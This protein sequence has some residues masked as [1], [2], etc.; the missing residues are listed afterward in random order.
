M[1][2]RKGLF[3]TIDGPNAAGK[4]TA[5]SGVA[6]QLCLL[7]YEVVTTGEPS[8]SEVGQLAR[9]LESECR[10]LAFACLI[11]SDRYFHLGYEV[12]PALADGKIVLS[13][14]YVESSLVLQRLDGVEF[15]LIWTINSKVPVPD[16]SVMLDVPVSILEQRLAERSQLDYYERNASR[17][18]EL[19]YYEDA[20]TFL[21]QHGYTFL[22]LSNGHVA[23]ADT[24]GRITR[25]ILRILECRKQTGR[26]SF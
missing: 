23:I 12:L 20:I 10:G 26:G 14:R 24:V 6:E 9:R 13:A 22:R 4:T 8:T 11:A 19:E 2:S 17:Q 21:S 1:N 25:E 7:G 3:V 18:Q 16:L 15:D 5:V